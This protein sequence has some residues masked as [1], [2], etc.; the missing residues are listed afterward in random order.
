M[1]SNSNKIEGV[2]YNSLL[3]TEVS[4]DLMALFL[5]RCDN[6]TRDDVKRFKKLL[7]FVPEL[8]IFI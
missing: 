7:D 4:E 6:V 8:R 3:V 2:Y 1:L 5:V